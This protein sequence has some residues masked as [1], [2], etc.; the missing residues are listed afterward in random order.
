ML[1]KDALRLIKTTA[2]RFISLVLIVLIGV[3]FMLGLFVTPNIMRTSVDEINKE[4]RLANIQIYSSYGFCEDDVKAL[5]A[6]NSVESVFASKQIDLFSTYSNSR[7]IVTRFRELTSDNNSFELSEGRLPLNEKEII[8]VEDYENVVPLNTKIK[9]F[10]D[11]DTDIFDYLKYD[12]YTIVGKVKSSEYMSKLKST[13]TLKNLDLQMIAYTKNS[14]FVSEYYTTLYV[15]GKNN[16]LSLFTDEYDKYIASF[17]KEI[18][19]FANKQQDYFK[20]TIYNESMEEI[21]EGEAKLEKEKIINL[22]KLNDAKKQLEDAKYQIDNGQSE[23]DAGK[24]KL[25]DGQNKIDD[26]YK[27]LE[28]GKQKLIDGEKKIDEEEATLNAAIKQIEDSQGKSFDEV[29]ADVSSLYD[30]YRQIEATKGQLPEDIKQNAI[31]ALQDLKDEQDALINNLRQTVASLDEQYDSVLI[32]FLKKQIENAQKTLDNLQIQINNAVEAAKKAYDNT[33]D[34]ALKALDDQVPGDLGV[35]DTYNQLLKLQEAPSQIQAARAEI[36]SGYQKLEQSKQALINGQKDI[37]Q[38]WIDYNAAVQKYY[39]AIA[40][41]DDGVKEYEK[42]VKEYNRQIYDAEIKLKEA[43]QKLDDLPDAKW[44]ILARESSYSN[45]MYNNTCDQMESICVVMP[46]LFYLVAALVCLTTMTRLIDEERGQIGIYRALGYK[47]SQILSKYLL[48]I[49]IACIIGSIFGSIFGVM[50]FPTVIYNTWR[51]MYNL[52]DM[53]VSVPFKHVII[54][55]SAFL[56]LLVIVTSYVVFKSLKETSASLLRPKAPKKAKK[57]LL[58]RI[59]FIWKL[60]SFTGKITVRN[61]FRYKARFLMSILGVAGCTSL[62]IMGFGVKDSISDVINLQYNEIFKY[63]YNVNLKD[64]LNIDEITTVLKKD[65]NTQSIM[66]YI[67]Y[68]SKVICNEK[69]DTVQISVFNE[70]TV[71]EMYNF[72]DSNNQ[73]VTFTNKTVAITEKYAEAHNIKVGDTITIESKE[74]LKAKVKVT[75][76]YKMYFQHF[77]FISEDIYKNTFDLEIHY[78]TIALKSTNEINTIGN[79]LKNIDGYNS[80][81]NFSGLIEQFNNMIRTL[82]NIIA[83]IIV[84]AG[85]LAFVVLFNLIQVNISERIREIATLKVLGFRN[86]EV[87]TYLFKEILLLTIIG[88]VLGMPL[89]K[90]ELEFVMTSINMEM[91]MFPTDI[92][93]ISYIYGFIISF[94]F[95]ILVLIYTRKELMK[96]KMVESLKSV[97]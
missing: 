17:E 34:A 95:T 22:N 21:T 11:D 24:Q 85:S 54:C 90:L 43:R 76:I 39:D 87:N 41:Y 29:L 14:N 96:I 51:L 71:K 52:P 31:G 97:E 74:G 35:V 84:T 8:V 94:I 32:D 72:K 26:G 60:F 47:K 79:Y 89:G 28:S 44:T 93:T 55:V 30:N 64:D 58:E 67:T 42:G 4:T 37:D 9:V 40:T 78:T 23:L 46:F 20:T 63:E 15:K 18:Q 38:G 56:V 45:Y 82:D 86:H 13:S 62:L 48:Y 65:K 59:P 7:N 12:E 75:D 27:Q 57:V 68:Y 81:T 80:I 83:V 92:K 19:T 25:I 1:I 10:F 88:G 2:K 69:T 33:I 91:I 5:K 36:T 53:I 6:L 77:I 73:D 16:D 50:I 3:A 49:F 70:K 61:L 66:P